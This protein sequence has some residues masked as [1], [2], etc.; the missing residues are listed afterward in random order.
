MSHRPSAK[1]TLLLL[2]LLLLLLW[3]SFPAWPQNS[4]ILCGPDTYPFRVE[5]AK[6]W[7]KKC[8]HR[9]FRE[10][11]LSCPAG[12]EES[13][14]GENEPPEPAAWTPANG[15]VVVLKSRNMRSSESITPKLCRWKQKITEKVHL[16]GTFEV[17][18]I[19]IATTALLSDWKRTCFLAHK[20]RQRW[21]AFTT[22][23]ILGMQ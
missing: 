23:K 16:S 7:A 5:G 17:L 18:V 8:K 2:L 12:A 13:D 15:N 1:R 19:R 20:D 9:C 3:W 22:E 21:A 11:V 14:K 4:A 6:P 10:E